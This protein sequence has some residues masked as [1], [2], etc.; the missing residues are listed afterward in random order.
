MDGTINS[1]RYPV[2]GYRDFKGVVGER[3]SESVAAWSA[4]SRAAKRA[5]NVVL[6]LMDDMGYS[7]IGPFGAEIDTPTLEEISG[8]G[9][10]LTNYQTPPLC[11]PARAALL[12]GLNPHRAGFGSVPHM[13]PGFP[14]LA[15]ELP[16]DAPTLAENFRAGGYATFMVGK[17]HLTPEAKMHDAADKSS[18]PVQRGFDR[19]YGAWTD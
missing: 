4:E 11:A 12:T 10:R 8:S 6:M 15:M 9:Y 13:D 18:W 2:R 5:P 1:G 3:A 14:N 7:D 17:W 19:Y 16:A